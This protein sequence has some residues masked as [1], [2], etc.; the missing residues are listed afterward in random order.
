MNNSEKLLIQCDFDGTVTIE[1][2]SFAILEAYIPGQWESLFAEY[3]DGKM[4]VGEFNTAVFTRVKADKPA[5]LKIVDE[6]V[7]V[8]NGFAD[9]VTYCRNRQYR[10][11]FVSNG[12]DFYIRH[13]LGKEGFNDMEVH[14]SITGFQPDGLVV[15]HKGPDGSFLDKD[16]KETFTDSFISQGYEVIYLGDGRSD[17]YPARKCRHVFTT[18]SLTG[19][20]RESGLKCTPFETFHDVI[21]AMELWQ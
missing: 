15:R 3:Q 14:A 8:R 7:T 16:V 4:T 6:K 18:G 20:C 12:L 13:I 10:I 11:V 2:A 9:F 19:Y 5:L 21:R 17:I 1:D